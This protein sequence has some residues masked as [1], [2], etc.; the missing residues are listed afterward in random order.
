M[1]LGPPGRW[2]DNKDFSRS[3][4]LQPQQQAQMDAVFNANKT[5]LFNTYRTLK[6]EETKLNTLQ[7][8]KEP[9][10]NA[11]LAQIDRVTQLRGDLAKSN[12]NLVL[13]LRKQLTSEQLQKLESMK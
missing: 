1:Q 12:T 5:A 6:A 2:W 4:N 9:D 8:A 7:S 10:E 11:I 13:Q 3:I